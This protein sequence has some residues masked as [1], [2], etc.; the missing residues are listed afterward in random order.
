[1]ETS[2]KLA[3]NPGC[4]LVGNPK[5]LRTSWQLVGNPG[6]QPELATSSYLVRLVGCGLKGKKENE[7]LQTQ[8]GWLFAIPP[9]AGPQY[10]ML[11]PSDFSVL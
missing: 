9:D 1:L 8:A 10:L 2:W 11:M 6:C 5:K 7:Q 4:Q 3:A